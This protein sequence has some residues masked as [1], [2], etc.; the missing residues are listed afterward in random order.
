MDTLLLSLFAARDGGGMFG[1]GALCC[2]LIY[3]LLAY[4]IFSFSLF[5][6]LDRLGEEDW[7][8]FAWIPIAQVF[9][10]AKAAGDSPWVGLLM[11]I[12]IVN[13][14]YLLYAQYRI[15]ERLGLSSGTTIIAIILNIFAP[16][17]GW[18][19]FLFAK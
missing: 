18:L 2:G 6:I 13:F 8:I 12:P 19:I 1:L 15:G 3:F 11:F 7:K 17:F 16:P 4:V 9:A 14:F 10:L 5:R